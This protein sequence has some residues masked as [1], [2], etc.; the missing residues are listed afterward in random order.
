MLTIRKILCPTDFS[1]PSYVGLKAANDLAIH[2]SDGRC[3]C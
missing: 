2:F 1:D 3:R